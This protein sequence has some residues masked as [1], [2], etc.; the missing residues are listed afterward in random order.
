[1]SG[2]PINAERNELAR[3]RLVGALRH[4]N[5]S[6]L[7]G[8]GVSVWAG[9]GSWSQ[10]IEHLAGAVHAVLPEVD[11][12][13]IIENNRNPLHCAK[14]LGAYLGPGF[15]EFIQTE[16]GPNG[17]KPN[18]LLF[19]LCS[20]PFKHFLTLNFD[21]S[22]EQINGALGRAYHSLTTRN[23]PDLIT[24]MRSHNG[25]DAARCVLHL[26]GTFADPPEYIALTN[27]GYA[28]LYPDGTLFRKFVWWLTTSK[29]LVFLGFGF[30]DSDFLNAIRQAAWDLRDERDPMHFAIRGIRPD[31]ND[32]AIR[33]ELNDSYKIEPVFYELAEDAQNRHAG[34][35]AL[36]ERIAADLEL[37]MLVP[38]VVIPTDAAPVAAPE[39]DDLRRAERLAEE[40]VEKLD[41]RGDD[42]PR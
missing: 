1:V 24:F 28:R 29:C 27:D 23:L 34:F 35:A 9:Y 16:F 3:N 10:V 18:D 8:A 22:L 7:V 39:P 31:E 4:G 36:I 5:S 21:Y 20:L 12:Q 41:P 25:V 32:E 40:L 17:K 30:T 37:P 11:T 2:L 13:R 38:P 6:A 42:V 19:R 15:A 33:N 14:H 26:H